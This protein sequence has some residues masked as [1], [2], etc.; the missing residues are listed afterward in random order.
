MESENM[1]AKKSIKLKI[2]AYLDGDLDQQGMQEIVDWIT[3]SKENARY[4]A[5]IKDLW[6]AALLDASQVAGTKK[7]W[8][9]FAAKANRRTPVKN[10]F[11]LSVNW[12]KMLQMAA[13]LAVGIF[14][15][16]LILNHSLKEAPAFITA[17][18]PKGSVSKIILPDNTEVFL[19]A[20]SEI[21]Y[22]F[23]R[24]EKNREVILNGE[25][26][27]KVTRNEKVPFIVHTG[28]YSVKVLGTE[29][30]V[31]SY[32]SDVRVETT[33]EKG[34]VLIGSSEKFRLNK[35]LTLKPGEQF[36]YNKGQNN[37]RVKQVDTRLYT[38]WKD[39]RLEFIR[40][41]LGELITLLERKYGVDI[42]VEDNSILQYHYSGTI[43]NETILEIL[44]MIQHTL[45]IRYEITDQ[46]IK[47][48]KKQ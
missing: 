4:Y 1:D 25:A 30:N 27:F 29:F 35:N 12:G 26:W 32:Q 36:V 16:G 5:G 15:G 47:I 43:K 7:E 48:Y 34:S 9:K 44:D 42:E 21:R 3:R 2:I 8:E 31:K 45:P 46:I 14:I 18:A 24:N 19:N 17:S 22:A 23:S 6:E 40:M 13:I 39:N 41:E 11:R 10:T 20:G 38:S 37:F 33:L 28:F